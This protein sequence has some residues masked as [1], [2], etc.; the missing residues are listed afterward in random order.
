MPLKAKDIAEIIGVSTATVSLVLNNKPGV[1]IQ[2]RQEIIQK[3]KELDCDYMLKDQRVNQG[4]I[5]FVVYKREGSII[6]ESPFFTYILEGINNSISKHGYH[7]NFIYINKSM[8]QVEQEYQLKSGNY[9]GLIIFAV[10]MYYD[11]LKFFKD[12]GIP[13]AILDNSFQ[14]ND[15][16]AV[17]I[18]NL[19]GTCKAVSYLCEMGHEQIGY[20]RSKVKINS[21]EERY[22]S[23]KHKLRSLGKNFCREY[24]IDVGYSE[25]EIKK[26]IK[27]YLRNHTKL[28]TAFFAENDFI[29]CNAIR[30]FQ[31]YGYCVPEDI[32]VVGFDNRPISTLI[33]PQLTT[34]DV[35]KDIF[36]PA[37]VELLISKIERKRDNSLKVEIGTSLVIRESVK[38]LTSDLV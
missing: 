29:G 26:D 4:S 19:Q 7:L 1:G 36:G 24:V 17:A 5:G 2:R 25:T 38:K 3:I 22:S 28:P 12:S 9:K 32:S 33:E 14:E 8:P 10:E 30:A 23:F 21:F 18:N 20:I 27:E 11:D 37:V 15:V 16:D 35:P 31:E 13:F 34:I 6:D